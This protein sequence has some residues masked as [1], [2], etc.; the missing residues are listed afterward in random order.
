VVPGSACSEQ[1]THFRLCFAASDEKLAK[2]V[3]ILNEIA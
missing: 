1:G 3:K 2:A